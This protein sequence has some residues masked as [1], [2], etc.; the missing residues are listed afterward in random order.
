MINVAGD[1]SEVVRDA[2]QAQSSSTAKYDAAWSKV[3]SIAGEKIVPEL[4]KLAEALAG[5]P[6][7]F[8]ALRATIGGLIDLLKALGILKRDQKDTPEIEREKERQKAIAA[9]KEIDALPEYSKMSPEQKDRFTTLL[10]ERNRASEKAREADA[11]AKNTTMVRSADQA[12]EAYLGLGEKAATPALEEDRRTKARQVFASIEGSGMKSVYGRDQNIGEFGIQENENQRML[13]SRHAR[14]TSAGRGEGGM[15]MGG[16]DAAI[17][18]L[19]TALRGLAGEADNTK[20]ASGQAAS[21]MRRL[22]EPMI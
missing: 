1:W 20:T 22:G 16:A 3:V 21:A 6:E 8:E 13:R 4:T 9:Q 19:V 18:A 17:N 5:S 12:M 15:V 2:A 11:I 14:L 10:A 7:I